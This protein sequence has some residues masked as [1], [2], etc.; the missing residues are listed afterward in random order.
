MTPTLVRVMAAAFGLC[1]LGHF[2]GYWAGCLLKQDFP[3]SLTMALNSGM[4]NISAGSVLAARYFPGDVLFPVAF[5][6]LFMQAVTAVIVRILCRA[7]S[8]R[9]EEK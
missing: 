3:T 6:P 8:G 5:S 7:R 4:R 1:V 2:L 9:T